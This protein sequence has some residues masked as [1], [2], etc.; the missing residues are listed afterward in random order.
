MGGAICM[1]GVSPLRSAGG[2]A[3][4]N[5]D[6]TTLVDNVPASGNR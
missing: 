1:H 4:T 2:A 5:D 3:G 6:W